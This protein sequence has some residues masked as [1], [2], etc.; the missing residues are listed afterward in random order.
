MSR[1]ARSVLN[2]FDLFYAACAAA[3]ASRAGRIP[4]DATLA[5]LGIDK[6]A[7]RRIKA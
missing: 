3:A 7:M 2:S 1:F 6:Q 5:R 4:S